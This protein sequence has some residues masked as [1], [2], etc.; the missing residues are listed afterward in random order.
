MFI[1][2]KYIILYIMNIINSLFCFI[3]YK[4]IS[5]NKGNCDCQNDEKKY[6]LLDF[7]LPDNFFVL[8]V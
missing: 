4:F 1:Q 8:Y 6:R 5:Y 7:S 3:K 2:K